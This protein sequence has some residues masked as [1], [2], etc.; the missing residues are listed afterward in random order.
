MK[1]QQAYPSRWLKAEQLPG[2]VEVIIDSVDLEDV[3]NIKGETEQKLVAM[4]VEPVYEGGPQR[5]IVNKTNGT[6]IARL[7]DSD[8]TDCWTGVKL[9]L[10]PGTWNGR[11]TIVVKG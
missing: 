10:T 3:T 11:P 8:E 4:F 1:Y 6:T 9:R 5:M 2:E 7:A